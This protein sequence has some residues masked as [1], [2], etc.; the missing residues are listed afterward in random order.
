VPAS[1]ATSEAEVDF[2]AIFDAVPGNYL[3]LAAD[4]DYTI[5]AAN[6]ARLSA[7]MTTR[8]DTIGKPL[9][10][11]FPD[12]PDDPAADGVRNLKASLERVIETGLP[13]TMA[14]QKYDIPKPE[15]EGGGFEEKYWSPKNLPIVGADG[16]VKYLIHRVEDVTDFVQLQQRDSEQQED[17]ARMRQEIIERSK[18]LQKA[19]EQL[20]DL[21]RAKPA[22]FNNV[23][24][25]FRTPIT[26]QLGP[27]EEALA[28]T[29][30]PLPP[31]QR[32]RVEMAYRNG[33]RLLKLVNSLLDFSR[34]ESGRMSAAFEPVDL[35]KL[36][37]QFA[38]SFESMF[39]SAGLGYSIECEPLS[40]QVYVDASMW[41][42]IVL[43]LVSN[44][45]KFTL[46]GNVA[47]RVYEDEGC[48]LEVSDTGS[49]IPED[50]LERV[51]DRFHRVE[52]T[53]GRSFEGSGIGLALTRELVDAHGGSITAAGNAAGG[54]TFTVRV[55]LGS[56]HLPADSVARSSSLET[57]PDTR[58][59][60]NMLLDEVRT[61]ASDA[62]TEHV[63]A[64]TPKSQARV[65]LV[66]DNPDMREYIRAILASHW[67]VEIATNGRE[68]LDAI[69]ANPPDV[70]L[71]DVMMPE[72][73][74]VEMINALRSDAATRSIPVILLSARAGEEAITQGIEE[75]ADD[76]LVKPFSAAE[77]IA[78][79]RSHV[80]RAQVMHELREVN[81]VKNAFVGMVSHEMQTPLMIVGDFAAL[82]RDRWDDTAEPEKFRYLTIIESYAQRLSRLVKS[83][84]SL[85]R[86]EAGVVVPAAQ[87]IDVTAV[88]K[89]TV[90]EL[91]SDIGV[92]IDGA[93]SND[94]AITA[95]AD[96]DHLHQ[97]L[98]NY[99][100]NA[101]RYGEPPCTVHIKPGAGFVEVR[102][103]DCGK[104]VPEESLA[105]LFQPFSIVSAHE[106][107]SG[108]GLSIVARLAESN[109]GDVW[110]EPRESG[111][112][113]F[114]F[115]LPLGVHED[116]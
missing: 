14:V 12:N 50:Q 92:V 116:A 62:E 27:L 55:P 24:H 56:A 41:E 82:L 9:F 29:A 94:V 89:S 86:M 1:G 72:M 25:E 67:R 76:Y 103:V 11:L 42:K 52:A 44:A 84:L 110:Y 16:H 97:I 73:S 3:I 100:S 83:V 74:G 57:V 30:N 22:F 111:G 71:S 20:R 32:E 81:E 70:V 26:L 91:G 6:D 23:S 75:G 31:Q 61:W 64:T 109:G 112:S 4:S 37:A 113:V 51:F 107:S 96:P 10:A 35:C 95:F 43:N 102:V 7:T 108:L 17:A 28:D 65:L 47:V 90:E 49:G 40:E 21:D 13:D 46:D 87:V 85:S 114:G 36:T 79:V 54:S 53:A 77:L 18:E 15:S 59:D 106:D 68:G 60:P 101:H 58:D 98:I 105:K 78:R 99:L 5:L 66:E 104:G 38:S 93:D 8:E 19:N 34:I 39:A 69:H 45:F 63:A 2:R 48:V 33:R 80:A 115:R 88:V